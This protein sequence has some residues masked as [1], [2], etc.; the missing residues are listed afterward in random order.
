MTVSGRPDRPEAPDRSQTLRKRTGWVWAT[1]AALVL[2]GAAFVGVRLWRDARHTHTGSLIASIDAALADYSREHPQWLAA[3]PATA[4]GAWH[5][6]DEAQTASLLAELDKGH[7]LDVPR[8]ERQ[9]GRVGDAWGRAVRI[10]VSRT[11]D[12]N[13]LYEIASAGPDG[14]WGNADDLTR[15]GIAGEADAAPATTRAADG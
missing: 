12:G 2:A 7:L 13:V 6:M 14:V 5:V 1:V 4:H 15:T 10:S 3:L 8:G 9:A 11:A